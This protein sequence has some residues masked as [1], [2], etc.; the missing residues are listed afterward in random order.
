M[1]NKIK[2]LFSEF[3]PVTTQQWEE[4]IM[5]DLKGADYEKKLIWKT[6]E[7]IAVK[8]YYTAEDLA[9]H[10]LDEIFSRGFSFYKRK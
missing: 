6:N 8:P 5:K 1:E 9:K 10:S 2:K 4:Q 7:G 3:P